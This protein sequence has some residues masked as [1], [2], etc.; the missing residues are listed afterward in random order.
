MNHLGKKELEKV[1]ERWL[2]SGWKPK[3]RERNHEKRRIN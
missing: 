1:T 3:K 2:K